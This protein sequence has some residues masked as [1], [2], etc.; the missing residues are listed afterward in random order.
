MRCPEAAIL[1]PLTKR[2][3]RTIQLL[4]RELRFNRLEGPDFVADELVHPVQRSLKLGLRCELPAHLRPHAT[5][6]IRS[7]E[8]RRSATGMIASPALELIVWDST[9][10]LSRVT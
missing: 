7:Q 6:R 3:E 4:G 8:G 5:R 10:A 1:D 2:G 9:N